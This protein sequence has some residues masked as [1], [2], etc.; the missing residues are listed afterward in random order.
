MHVAD[1]NYRIEQFSITPEDFP[2]LAKLITESFLNE[3]LTEQNGGSILF[4]VQTF[5]IMF[6]SPII[7][8]D[9][10][11]RAIHIPTNEIVG[12]LGAVPRT[13]N[14]KGTLLNYVIPSF[15]A[16]HH[17][18]RRKGLASKMGVKLREI[19]IEKDVD[20]GFSMHEPE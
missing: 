10:F 7:S 2:G 5:N 17:K 19:G 12:F 20:G 14:M 9:F 18:H 15:A 16:V 11:V 8:R 13:V 1:N 4:D 6:G 3:E